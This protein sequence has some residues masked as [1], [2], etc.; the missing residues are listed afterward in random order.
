MWFGARQCL[1]AG[2][3]RG[4]VEDGR[5]DAESAL[6]SRQLGGFQPPFRRLLQPSG[7]GW[8]VEVARASEEVLFAGVR[9]SLWG[10]PTTPRRGSET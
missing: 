9:L 1:L 10:G 7:L 3:G 8:D 2:K 6:C 5:R 4:D